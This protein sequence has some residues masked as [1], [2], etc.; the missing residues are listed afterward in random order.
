MVGRRWQ[1]RLNEAVPMGA[2]QHAN[3]DIEQATGIRITAHHCQE[4]QV[5]RAAATLAR[6]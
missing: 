6:Q 1:A 2:R 4:A 3:L 5:A